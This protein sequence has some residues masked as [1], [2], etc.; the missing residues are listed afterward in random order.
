MGQF[1]CFKVPAYKENKKL[2]LGSILPYVVDEMEVQDIDNESDWKIA[3]IKYQAM[4]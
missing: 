2:M 3:E 4:K 1:Y